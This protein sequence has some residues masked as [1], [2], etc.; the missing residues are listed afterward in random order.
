MHMLSNVNILELI[1]E[2]N[3]ISYISAI[4]RYMQYIQLMFSK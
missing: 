1:G 4:K 2:N 3:H